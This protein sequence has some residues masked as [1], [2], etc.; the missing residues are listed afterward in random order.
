[1]KDVCALDGPPEPLLWHSEFCLGDTS[2]GPVDPED[3]STSWPDVFVAWDD[4]AGDAVVVSRW[5]Y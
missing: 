1:M 4:E 5:G 3:P 2:V